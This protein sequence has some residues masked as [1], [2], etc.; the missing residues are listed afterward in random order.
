MRHSRQ[1]APDACIETSDERGCL[2]LVKHVWWYNP[3][4]K[5]QMIKLSMGHNVFEKGGGVGKYQNT[6]TSKQDETLA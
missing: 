2:K 4:N 6:P 1:V 5:M 3:Y